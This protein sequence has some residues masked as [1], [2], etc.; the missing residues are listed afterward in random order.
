MIHLFRLFCLLIGYSFGCLQFA[1]IIGKIVYKTDIR[2]HGSGNA[3]T[4]NIGRTFGKKV[5]FIVF[6]LDVVK[7]VAAFILCAWFF[8]GATAFFDFSGEASNFL[9]GFYGAVGVILGHNFPL[10]L[11]FKGG[12]GIACSVGLLLIFD[13]RIALIVYAVGIITIAATRYVSLMSLLMLAVFPVLTLIFNHSL[14]IFA[15]SLFL[16]ALAFFQ[17]RTN[18]TR[19]LSKTERKAFTKSK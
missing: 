13:W 11:D 8:K 17:H 14:E 7:C 18:I 5:G 1:Y 3:G 12:K 10:F 19:L 9:P 15:L 4:T 6:L 16:T 2:T